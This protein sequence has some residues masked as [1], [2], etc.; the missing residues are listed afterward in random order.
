MF[1]KNIDFLSLM[2]YHK[3]KEFRTRVLLP[4]TEVYIW[5]T[6]NLLLKC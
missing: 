3:N 4:E 5:I 1:D 2:M 6:K